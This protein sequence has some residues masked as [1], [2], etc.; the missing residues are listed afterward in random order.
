MKYTNNVPMRKKEIYERA[1]LYDHA[2]SVHI[3]V[4]IDSAGGILIKRWPSSFKIKVVGPGSWIMVEQRTTILSYVHS[5]KVFQ[6]IG[7]L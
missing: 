1:N 5:G 7:L 3:S 4:Y 6:E 2:I